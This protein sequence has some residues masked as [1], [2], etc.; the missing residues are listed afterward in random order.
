MSYRRGIIIPQ[1]PDKRL[2]D[3]HGDQFLTATLNDPGQPHIPGRRRRPT[4]ARPYLGGPGPNP[5]TR[6]APSILT[7]PL[8]KDNDLTSVD[9]R[10]GTAVGTITNIGGR[11]TDADGLP[12]AGA[13][14]EIWQTNAFG[15]YHH[16]G[17]RSTS[18]LDPNFQGY[19]QT[20]TDARG[21]YRFRTIRPAPYPGRTPHIHFAIK[22]PDA[23]RLVTQMYLAGEPGNARDRLLQSIRDPAERI[24]QPE[25]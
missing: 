13:L 17:D 4:A 7:L 14:V 2:E 8:D 23:G 19:G 9:G 15:R 11:V 25:Y 22:P 12:Q 24:I 16:P 20:V 5:A 21:Q 3:R 18:P 10:P 1:L 6:P